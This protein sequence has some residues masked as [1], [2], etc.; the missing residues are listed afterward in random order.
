MSRRKVLIQSDFSL[1][2]TG[3]A[4]NAKTILSYLYR[5]GKYDIVHYCCGLS[6]KHP[7][8][9]RTPWKSIG[10][11]PA[12]RKKIQEIEKDPTINKIAAY[13]AYYLDN[14]VEAEK[15]DV[16]IAIQDIWG[17]DFATNRK[18]FNKIT[19]AIWTTLDSLPILP[20]AI[21]TAKKVK[22]YWVWSNFATKEL[23][24]IG[25]ENVKTLHGALE[26]KDFFPLSAQ[27]KSSLRKKNNISE[28]DFLIGFVF[29]NQLRK[30]IPNLLQGFKKFKKLN[31]DSNAKLLLHTHMEEGWPI[32][33]LAKEQ[34]INVNDILVTHI[35]SKCRNFSVKPYEGP[36]KRCNCCENENS[37]NST[38]VS[39][40]VDENQLNQVYNLMDAYCH[41]FTSGGQ[42]IPIQEA[43]LTEL[44]T[45]VTNYS[46]G[47]EMCEQEAC[48]LPLEWSEYREFG[49][50]FIKASTHPD[51]IA[52]Q[53]EKVYKMDL[54]QRKEMGK[55]ARRWVIDNFSINVIGK[56]LED[57]ID[58]SPKIKAKDFPVMEK[59]DPNAKIPVADSQSHWI[60][61]LYKLILKTEVA[62][63]DE[64]LKYWLT[65]LNKGTPSG[66]IEKYFRRVALKDNVKKEENKFKGIVDEDDEGK[67]LLFVIPDDPIDIFSC[68]SLFK[69]IKES[70]KGF[71]LYV[72]TRKEFFPIL[73]GNDFIHK[74]ITY[75][76][77]HN[78]VKEIEEKK[79]FNVVYTPQLNNLNFHHFNRDVTNYCV[80]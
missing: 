65:E 58:S 75:D 47:A 54:E 48:S 63:D 10:C 61:L 22:N 3:F 6:E 70:Y 38:G 24:R 33:S 23:N 36:N 45:L 35:C 30:S 15:P 14:V 51:S 20:T 43:K 9:P 37:L 71:N 57:F 80:L 39:M 72:A 7:D 55:K 16:Y 79:Y 59:C 74:V 40:G 67:R 52:L 12:S 56:K 4:K 29:R 19:S 42:E 17:V 8:L 1:L 77:Y 21:E 49:S 76:E 28:K 2:K 41:P 5:T 27:E 34:K 64:G 73:E 69:S 25:Y 62:D 44:I 11:L 32:L 26:D 31:P 60:K 78:N 13:G 53:L 18:W 46:C 66:V 50:N 68:T